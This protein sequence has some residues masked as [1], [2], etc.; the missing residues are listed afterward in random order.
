MET[1]IVVTDGHKLV[2][3][4]ICELLE[5]EDGVSVVAKAENS[6]DTVRYCNGHRPDVVL[7][8]PDSSNCSNQLFGAIRE[9]SP[10][11]G[12]VVMSGTDCPRVTHEAF[13]CGIDGYVLKGEEPEALIEAVRS[14]RDG[15][16]YLNPR[17]AI[18]IAQMEDNDSGLTD[19]EKEILKLIAYG[20]TNGQIA[21]ELFLSVRT[22]ESHRAHIMQKLDVT[23]RCGLVK[24]AIEL[25]LME[26]SN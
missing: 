19:R 7:I 8:D 3:E 16:S 15:D 5:K 2:R 21:L 1:K 26:I 17:L 6:A 10:N 11:T 23:D 25:G 13:K 18:Q 20:Y 9:S 24:S 14:A 4:G 22:V 12:I